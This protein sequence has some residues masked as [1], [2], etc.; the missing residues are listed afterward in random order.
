MVSLHR[1]NAR[2]TLYVSMGYVQMPRTHVH[3]DY[4]FCSLVLSIHIDRA[5]T[6]LYIP[7]YRTRT[8]DVSRLFMEDYNNYGV[9]VNNPPPMVVCDICSCAMT[10]EQVVHH[11]EEEHN[12]TYELID[13]TT[14]PAWHVSLPGRDA[15]PPTSANVAGSD[16]VGPSSASSS[17]TSSSATGPLSA[18]PC[19]V[20]SIGTSLSPVRTERIAVDSELSSV[21]RAQLNVT[22]CFH[23]CICGHFALWQANVTDNCFLFIYF[24][25][26]VTNKSRKRTIDRW[27]GQW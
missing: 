16:D 23:L 6:S 18:Q 26:A 14:S 21:F 13:P 2:T 19:L 1:S 8:S 25:P 12:Q 3:R 27:T 5:C 20:A 10:P 4:P 7:T 11:A 22:I 15:M 24:E 17:S 9:D